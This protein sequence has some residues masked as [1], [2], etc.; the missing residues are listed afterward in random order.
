METYTGREIQFT[1][2]IRAMSKIIH[3]EGNYRDRR[4]ILNKEKTLGNNIL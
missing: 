3:P 4:K 2:E 1:E